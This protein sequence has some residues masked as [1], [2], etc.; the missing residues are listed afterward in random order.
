MADLF[1]R[2]SLA[3]TIVDGDFKISSTE[4]HSNSDACHP[5]HYKTGKLEA[6][7]I[8]DA[9][10]DVESFDIGNVIK[11]IYRWK[12]KNGLEDLKKARVYLDHVIKHI[13]EKEND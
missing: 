5:D 6:W 13:E 1:A 10:A 12:N 11:Y 3:E 7:D 2:R 4:R 9:V 8:I